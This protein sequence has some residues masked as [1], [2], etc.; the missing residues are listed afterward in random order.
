M[1]ILQKLEVAL[2]FKSFLDVKGQ[3]QVFEDILLYLSIIVGHRIKQSFLV[4]QDVVVDEVVVHPL[5]PNLWPFYYFLI[6]E[7]FTSGHHSLIC[8]FFTVQVGSEIAFKD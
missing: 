7:I 3:R 2:V 8:V 5:I 6:F 1:I 4:P